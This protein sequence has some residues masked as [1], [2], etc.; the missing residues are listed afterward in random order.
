MFL[1]TDVEGLDSR[2]L[3]GVPQLA[4]TGK[5]SNSATPCESTRDMTNVGCNELWRECYQPLNNDFQKGKFQE[6]A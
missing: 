6:W 3:G 5:A 2:N 1:L 4:E